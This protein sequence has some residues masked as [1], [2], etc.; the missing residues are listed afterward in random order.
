MQR[1]RSTQKSKPSSL[2]FV[3]NLPFTVDKEK[4]RAVFDGYMC[5]DVR[6]PWD[7]YAMR[8]DARPSTLAVETLPFADVHDALNLQRSEGTMK[9][10]NLV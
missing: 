2:L 9:N 8:C 1:C 4:V 10:Y 6:L 3:A 7:M 5:S